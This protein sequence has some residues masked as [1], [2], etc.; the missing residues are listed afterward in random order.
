MHINNQAHAVGLTGTTSKRA[1]VPEDAALISLDGAALETVEPFKYL[2]SLI[3]NTDSQPPLSG[4]PSMSKGRSAQT[5][6]KA[7]YSHFYYYDIQK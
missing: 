5:D 1:L 4:T 2:G 6:L 7:A 3:T